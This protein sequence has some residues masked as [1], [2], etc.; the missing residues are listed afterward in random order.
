M[1]NFQTKI[2]KQAEKQNSWAIFRKKKDVVNR[3]W[4]CMGEDADFSRTKSSKFILCIC[5]R[6]WKKIWE[7]QRTGRTSQQQNVNYLKMENLEQKNEIADINYSL[8]WL[9][10]KLG[11]EE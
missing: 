6:N 4:I 7:N 10:N 11:M 9:D 5:L 1:S 3:N 2:T 8:D